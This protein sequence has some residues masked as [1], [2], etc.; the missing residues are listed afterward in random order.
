MSG[1]HVIT[2]LFILT[3][4][5]VAGCSDDGGADAQPYV[6][7]LVEAF[8]DDGD[9]ATDDEA[10]CVAE[11]SVEAIGADFLEDNDI[12]P[13][14]LAESD[15]P[16]DLDIDISED[17]ARGAASALVDCDIS[18]GALFAG[19]DAS[20]EAIACIDENLDEDTLV[21]AGTAEYLG[22]EDEANALY[23]EAFA[24]IEEACADLF[25]G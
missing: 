10:E 8:E 14:D 6:D 15:G 25:G 1:R 16:Q 12:S 23:G 21:D 2:A 19:D 7:A 5:T 9:F 22:D 3:S 18:W 24:A 20:D 11:A 4:I 17:Q 13:E